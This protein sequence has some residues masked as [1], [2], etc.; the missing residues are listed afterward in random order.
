MRRKRKLPLAAA[1]ALP[2]SAANSSAGQGVLGSTPETQ[3]AAA[4]APLFGAANKPAGQTAFGSAPLTQTAADRAAEQIAA[5]HCA[6]EKRAQPTD[7]SHSRDRRAGLCPRTGWIRSHT[8]PAIRAR[9]IAC[10]LNH[11]HHTMPFCFTLTCPC[12]AGREPP[13]PKPFRSETRTKRAPI[14]RSAIVRKAAG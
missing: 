13:F 6:A 3:A 11:S 1:P 4:P 8:L 12:A 7:R 14:D 9:H 10:P 5:K 2:S